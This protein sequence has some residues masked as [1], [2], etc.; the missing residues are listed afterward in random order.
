MAV[1]QIE[2]FQ[3]GE[4]GEVR[5]LFQFFPIYYSKAD[6]V[7]RADPKRFQIICNI[8]QAFRVDG[9]AVFLRDGIPDFLSDRFGFFVHE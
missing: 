3:V 2:R 4:S 7:L 6:D 5:N 1:T 9:E 8:L